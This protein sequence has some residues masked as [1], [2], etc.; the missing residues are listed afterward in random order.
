M[1]FSIDV[2]R[3]LEFCR[4]KKLKRKKKKKTRNLLVK[5]THALQITI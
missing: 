5:K 1:N 4:I 3:K 2:K